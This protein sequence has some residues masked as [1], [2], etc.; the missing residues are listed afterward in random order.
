M[1]K[2]NDCK[3]DVRIVYI[4]RKWECYVCNIC[5]KIQP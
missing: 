3:W 4:A 5:D 1:K 2:C